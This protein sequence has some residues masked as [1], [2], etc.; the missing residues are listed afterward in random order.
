M[1]EV[2]RPTHFGDFSNNLPYGM[3]YLVSDN[4]ECVFP[5]YTLNYIVSNDHQKERK[6]QNDEILKKNRGNQKLNDLEFEE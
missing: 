6:R 1:S 2:F 3:N 4:R 5:D